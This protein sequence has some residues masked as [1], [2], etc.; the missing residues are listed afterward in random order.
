MK[1]KSSVKKQSPTIPLEPNKPPFSF[2]DS[3][4][5]E[6]VPVFSYED[7]ELNTKQIYSQF[8]SVIKCT[9]LSKK[10]QEAISLVLTLFRTSGSNWCSYE[11]CL[12]RVRSQQK[13][14]F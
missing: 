1:S 14:E 11:T 4:N 10:E 3:D 8:H 7:V 12:R 13:R 5:A 2:I 9:R 6:K